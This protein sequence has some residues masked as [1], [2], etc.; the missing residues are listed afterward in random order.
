MKMA[1][2]AKPTHMD[3]LTANWKREG[4]WQVQLGHFEI[5]QR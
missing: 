3:W 4:K 1:R 5:G 2:R